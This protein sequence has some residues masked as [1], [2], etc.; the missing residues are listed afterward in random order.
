[1]SQDNSSQLGNQTTLPKQKRS[2]LKMWLGLVFLV[3]L[4]GFIGIVAEHLTRSKSTFVINRLAASEEE[5]A[6]LN[7]AEK[8]GCPPGAGGSCFTSNQAIAYVEKIKKEDGGKRRD[9]EDIRL[10]IYRKVLYEINIT[11]SLVNLLGKSTD[12][13][14]GLE[15]LG[16]SNEGGAKYWDLNNQLITAEECQSFLKDE[17]YTVNMILQDSYYC[18]LCG[19]WTTKRRIIY[20][21]QD[22]NFSCQ[23]TFFE[24]QR[25]S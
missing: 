19:R 16:L 9:F 1:M 17:S 10:N 6:I 13:Y 21:D 18:P 5:R 25:I 11:H 8:V 24:S 20:F 7:Q 15:D 3:L 14:Y 2:H 23:A 4:V 22:K 12:D